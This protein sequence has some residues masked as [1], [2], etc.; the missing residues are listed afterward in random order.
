MTLVFRR[1]RQ[2]A[3]PA[4]KSAVSDSIFLC[5]FYLDEYVHACLIQPMAMVYI[6]LRP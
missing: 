6:R 3:A 5:V 4:A 1:V 2:V